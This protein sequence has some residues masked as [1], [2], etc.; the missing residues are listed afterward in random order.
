MNI[1]DANRESEVIED[2]VM[3]AACGATPEDVLILTCE[4]NLCL[5]CAASNLHT[6]QKR[7]KNKDMSF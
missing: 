5:P 7:Q 2:G 6:A 4:H 1:D 3:C